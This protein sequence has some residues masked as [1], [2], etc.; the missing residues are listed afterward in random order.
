MGIWM[1]FALVA[2]GGSGAR[3]DAPQGGVKP[4]STPSGHIHVHKYTPKNN[5]AAGSGWQHEGGHDWTFL[6]DGVTD[7]TVQNNDSTEVD[8]GDYTVT[9]SLS[10]QQQANG[11]QLVDIYIPDHG[12]GLPGGGNDQCEKDGP[13]STG[14]RQ[15]AAQVLASYFTDQDHNNNG[16]IHVCAFDNQAPLTREVRVQKVT[17]AASHPGATFAVAVGQQS[18]QVTLTPG[19]AASAASI[20]SGAPV[21][22]VLTVTETV[23]ASPAGWSLTGF[24]VRPDTNHGATCSATDPGWQQTAAIP[25][26]ANPYMVC[27]KNAYAA[28]LTTLT[29]RAYKAICSSFAAVPRNEDGGVTDHYG[30]LVT[31][32]VNAPTPV[33]AGAPLPQGCGLSTEPFGFR[34]AYDQNPVDHPNPMPV[35]GTDFGPTGSGGFAEIILDRQRF[36]GGHAVWIAEVPKTG[37]AFAGLRC[38]RDVLNQDNA[39]WIRLESGDEGIQTAYCIAYNVAT[40]SIAGEKYHDLDANGLRGPSEP[41]LGG[42]TITATRVDSHP[43]PPISVETNSTGAFIFQGVPEGVYT[44][45]ET[46]QAEWTVTQPA[47]AC[48]TRTLA[49]G[50]QVTGLQFGNSRPAT[51]TVVKVDLGLNRTWTFDAAG[52]THPPVQSLTGNGST[53]FQGLKPGVYNVTETNGSTGQCRP[54]ESIPGDFETRH[55]STGNSSD[56]IPGRTMDGIQVASGQAVTVY[57][58]NRNCD[59][60]LGTPTLYIQKLS[61]PDGNRSGTEGLDGFKFTVRRNGNPIA[62]SPF[63]SPPGGLIVLPGLDVGTYTVEEIAAP[64][65]VSTGFKTDMGD[66]GTFETSGAGQPG[67]IELHLADVARVNVYNQLQTTVRVHKDVQDAGATKPGEGWEFSLTGCGVQLTA[68][69]NAGGDLEWR[70]PY[71][72]GCVYR[73]DEEVRSGWVAQ[74]A[75][76]QYTGP[77]PGNG[78][79]VTFV[80]VRQEFVPSIPTPEPICTPTPTSTATPPA[81]LPTQRPAVIPTDTPTPTPTPV[82][83]VGGERTPGPPKSGT[84]CRD[85]AGGTQPST[86]TLFAVLGLLAPLTAGG[87][88]ALYVRSR[89]LARNRA[90]QA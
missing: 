86:G 60:L 5:P 27:V 56:S 81:E 65:H 37:Y 55:G 8:Q 22:Q 67:P 79:I 89:H 46:Q 82:N 61:D 9:E 51:L 77:A 41:G 43:N 75:A 68:V 17:A 10:G 29:V 33:A 35:R 7:Y 38:H 15:T 32:P 30:E 88:V 49:A 2:A 62:G 34:Y 84:G 78:S 59:T 50:G 36:T 69:T 3:A 66:D 4:T 31:G 20:I 21:N 44:V 80:N 71:R 64:P 39:E 11:W 13:R 54:G 76:F 52:P 85:T 45:C 48:Y 57:F 24:I 6:V 87:G 42:W 70:L 16:T 12:K 28:P 23:P 72:H 25:A 73:V 74:P 40:G 58:F 19:A 1:L 18:T 90:G 26:D 83:V 53:T 63:V 47:G 14:Q